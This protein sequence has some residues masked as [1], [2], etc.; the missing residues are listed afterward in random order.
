MK[1]KK[2]VKLGNFQIKLFLQEE[3]EAKPIHISV[4]Y[5]L[6]VEKFNMLL[7]CLLPY[8]HP[9]TYLKYTGSGAQTLVKENELNCLYTWF[10]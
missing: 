8:T 2:K 6:P 1:N 10:P 5:C 7:K 4:L 9:I 3:S